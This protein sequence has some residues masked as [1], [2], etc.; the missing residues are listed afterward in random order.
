MCFKSFTESQLL[1]GSHGTKMVGQ[2][3]AWITILA[4]RWHCSFLSF[5]ESHWEGTSGPT[6]TTVAASSAHLMAVPLHHWLH[7]HSSKPGAQCCPCWYSVLKCTSLEDTWNFQNPSRHADVLCH[8]CS[9]KPRELG[10]ALLHIKGLCHFDSTSTAQ[11]VWFAFR[12]W[13][14]YF[15]CWSVKSFPISV[16]FKI[17]WLEHSFCD[18]LLK[19]I[20]FDLTW[21]CCDFWF[22]PHSSI[23]LVGCPV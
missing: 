21:S 2:S 10:N 6:I 23:Y 15:S 7:W 8:P 4:G 3:V 18:W 16:D 22:P 12:E 14:I 1:S 11:S 9:F 20:N 13:G 17:S 5:S 19:R